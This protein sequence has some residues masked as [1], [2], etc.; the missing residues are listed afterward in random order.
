MSFTKR[1]DWQNR[2]PAAQKLQCLIQVKYSLLEYENY[3]FKLL[4]Q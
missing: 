2:E 4:T 1:R 3:G